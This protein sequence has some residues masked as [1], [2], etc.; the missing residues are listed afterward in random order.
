[1]MQGPLP[2][3]LSPRAWQ[4]FAITVFIVCIALLGA[5][6]LLRVHRRRLH[7]GSA[8]GI[9]KQGAVF[10][11]L[12]LAI[13]AVALHTKVNFLVL[14][15]STLFSAAL[16][17][18]VLSRTTMRRITFQRRAPGGVYPDQAFTVELLA[19]NG[20]SV[21]S[22][23]GL[24]VSDELPADVAS[25]HPGDVVL[26]LRA[27]ET[28]SI[29]YT[30]VASRRGVFAL[31]RVALST[32]FPFGFFHQDR[33]RRVESELVVY[34]RL[35]V[36]SPNL[37]GRAQT[38][39]QTRRTSQSTRGEEE[40]RNLREYRHGDNP[41]WIH[42]KTSAKL[43]R[44]LV[45][46]H[47]A[48]VAERVF[49]VLDTRAPSGGSPL[50][51][52]AI[53]FTASLARDL[54]LRDFF[55]AFAAYAPELTVTAPLKGTAGLHILLD[56]LAR[57]RPAPR[58]SLRELVAEPKVRTQERV[59]TAAVLLRADAD[60]AAAIEQLQRRR[61]RVVVV[62]AGAPEFGRVFRLPERASQEEEGHLSPSSAHDET[63]S[64]S[65]SGRGAG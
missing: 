9:T 8:Q 35:G 48:V 7:R 33:T 18:I 2:L 59:L 30:A 52:D 10:F 54:M 37:L 39:A 13:G 29:P 28:L 65:P 46:E 26:Q 19:T 51:E 16:L 3:A 34:P 63:P 55:V 31:T 17:S 57:L 24:A 45:K 11:L 58:R 1:M 23:Y 36:V 20:K 43:G 49:I 64:P 62:D 61:P 50:L 12:T 56:V 4:P 14:L 27:G 38:L 47:E 15:F 21:F 40:F 6:H 22:S 42:W 32:R 44:P 53:S 25:E 41:R 5:F 60:S